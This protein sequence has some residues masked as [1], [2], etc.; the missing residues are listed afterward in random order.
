MALVLIDGVTNSE[1]FVDAKLSLTEKR[2]GEAVDK[3]GALLGDIV[4]EHGDLAAAAAPVYYEYGKACLAQAESASN[5]FGESVKDKKQVESEKE[6]K[7][8]KQ[9]AKDKEGGNAELNVDAIL[10]ELVNEYKKNNGKDPTDDVLKQWKEQLAGADLSQLGTEPANGEMTAEEVKQV[11]PAPEEPE[12]SSEDIEELLNIAWEVLETGRV[13]VSKLEAESKSEEDLSKLRT[14]LANTYLRL[15]DLSMERGL[16]DESIQDYRT[17]LDKHKQVFPLWA[18]ELADV[19]THLAIAHMFA[20]SNATI[21][22]TQR[23]HR[24]NGVNCLILAIYTLVANRAEK[25]GKKLE[26]V[27]APALSIKIDVTVE[28]E[29][30]EEGGSSKKKSKG[31]AKAAVATED[32]TDEPPL[33]KTEKKHVDNAKKELERVLKDLPWEEE[34]RKD[35]AA[36]SKDCLEQIEELKMKVD[37]III[38]LENPEASKAISGAAAGVVEQTLDDASKENSGF[39][40]PSAGL[41]QAGGSATE[42]A[43]TNTLQPRKKAETDTTKRKLSADESETSKKAKV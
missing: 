12:L 42:N 5:I 32:E 22:T 31:K 38:V 34:K 17:S 25:M 20:S 26:T 40:K 21:V 29:E 41:D 9:E 43:P 16:F 3:F 39:D 23:S 33:S 19:Y 11:V 15:G 35:E 36:E 30:E 2:Y 1:R 13:I 28:E 10:E 14:M 18:K 24:I 6:E 8:T 4:E 37:D 7:E 27:A